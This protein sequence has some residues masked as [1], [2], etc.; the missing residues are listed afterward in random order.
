MHLA[1]CVQSKLLYC[2]TG[3]RFFDKLIPDNQK[4]H[5]TGAGACTQEQQE[6][7]E[8]QELQQELVQEEVKVPDP[9]GHCGQG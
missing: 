1:Q 5:K 6:E 9:P 4:Q 7:Q 3:N 8:E 2:L